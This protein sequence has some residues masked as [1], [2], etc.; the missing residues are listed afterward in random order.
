M[1]IGQ[2]ASVASDILPKELSG[3]L[4]SLQKEA[5]PMPYEV[6]AEQIEREFGAP[7]EVLF[8]RFEREPFAAASIGQVHRAQVDDGREVVVHGEAPLEVRW[9]GEP[10]EPQA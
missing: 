4:K 8:N 1:K 3:A 5:P 9:L 10:R 2:M 7:P 6:I